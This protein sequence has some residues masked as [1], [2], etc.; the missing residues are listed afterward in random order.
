VRKIAVAL[1][2]DAATCLHVRQTG[3]S[4]TPRPA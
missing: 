3:R 2:K 4:T 1:I